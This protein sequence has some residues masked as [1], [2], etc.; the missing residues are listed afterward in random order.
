MEQQIGGIAE[1]FL[2]P[3]ERARLVGLC[4]KLTGNRDIAEDL[5]QETLLLAWRNI[6]GLRDPEKRAQWIGGI[7]R[8]VS[9]RWLRQH[10]RDLAH[11]LILP[12]HVEE[13]SIAT[14]E[15]MVADEFDL[16]VE[17]E[18]KELA[19][20][21]DRALALLPDE[22]R[23][24]L[25]KRYID[26]SPLAEIAA[27]LGTNASTIAM[28]LQRGKLALRKVLTSEM[29]EEIA[30][31]QQAVTAQAWEPTSIWCWLCGQHHL[32]GKRQPERGLLYLKCP[33]CSPDDQALNKSEDVP[34]L[35]SIKSFKPALARLAEWSHTYYRGG[36]STGLVACS[37]CGRAVPAK[38][39]PAEEIPELLWLNE[40]SP[41]WVWGQNDRL[42]NIVCSHCHS[43]NS[44]SLEALVICLPEGRDFQRAH[45]RIQLLPNRAIDVAGQPAIITT[46][47][48][49]TAN[50]RFEVI[51]DAATYEVLQIHG[52]NK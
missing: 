36:L 37:T 6:E 45:Q 47:E 1:D 27:Q 31:Y 50:A 52:G 44:I 33:V 10:G 2:S 42:V 35:K 30:A 24:V 49:L 20:L 4:G 15:E 5:A 38:I 43:A 14:L 13:Q 51:S 40:D 7:A 18:R 28:R 34:F 29:Q 17:L 32:L 21:L 41:R 9:L 12:Q 19:N 46:F 22:T 23:T 26:E 8:N 11:S 39:S 16:E 48:S 3:I 25:I